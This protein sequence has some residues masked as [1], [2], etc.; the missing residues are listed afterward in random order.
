MPLSGLLS[1][2]GFAGGWPSIF[3]VFGTVGT[4]WCV[5]FLLMV[6]EDPETHPRISDEEKKYI[7]S[8]LWGSAGAS[9][10]FSSLPGDLILQ[11]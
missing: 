2:H 5:A 4:I 1:D 8:S 10:T 3:Y 6:H 11:N 9:V 7:L